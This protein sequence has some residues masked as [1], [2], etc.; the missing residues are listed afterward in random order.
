M[1]RLIIICAALAIP[2]V[3]GSTAL[4]DTFWM[5][6]DDLSNMA[7]TES[8]PAGASVNPGVP[9]G[10]LTVNYAGQ[11]AGG[12]GW[13]SVQIGYRWS[14]SGAAGAN[15]Y[16]GNPFPDLTGYDDFRMSFH[17][18]GDEYAVWG[19]LFINTGYTDDGFDEVDYFAQIDTWQ[20]AEY[21][22]S[23]ILVLD[24]DDAHIWQN[25][26]PDGVYS[27][28][29]DLGTGQT[30]PLLDHVTGI[31][32]A[33]ATRG[34]DDPGGPAFDVDVDTVPVPGAVLLGMLGLS[35]AGI[36]LRRFA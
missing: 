29:V 9:V 17:N 31:G 12:G 16:N 13:E 5:S 14:P 34:P 7:M 32:F 21:C 15:K 35:V 11:T 27:N 24:F 33:V 4:A 2:L 22:D 28:T 36:K 18:Q 26:Y 23:M 19:N 25:N 3:L 30:I 6:F 20:W 10:P 1:K 8:S